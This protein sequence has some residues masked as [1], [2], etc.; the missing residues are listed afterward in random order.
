MRPCAET[1][2]SEMTHCELAL[3]VDVMRSSDL[4]GA[5]LEVG[6][7]AG[8]TLWRMM[9]CYDDQDGPQFV[10]VDPMTY[11]PGQ[12]EKV[13]E[14][15]SKHGVDPD[16]VEFRLMLSEEAVELA[17][18]REETYDF[19]FIDGSHK[20]RRVVEDLRW[21]ERLNVGGVVAFHDYT[22][23]LRGVKLA[24]DHF[25]KSHPEFV[26]IGKAETL[27]ILKKQEAMSRQAVSSLDRMR[28][29]LWAPLLQL[30]LSLRKKWRRW[31]NGLK[32]T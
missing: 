14:N 3:L 32:T 30:E 23:R 6:T 5:H 2:Q 7:A 13:R 29:F 19:I 31:V 15:L 4:R 22:P 20:I 9:R 28:A 21:L 1:G 10:V 25:L 12:L 24:I 17:E 26:V 18:S 27:L 11:F 8:G 16:E